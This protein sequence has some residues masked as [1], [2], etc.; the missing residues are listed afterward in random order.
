MAVST[1]SRL[2]QKN[3]AG[4]S[5][6]LFLEVFSGLVLE[7]F[8]FTQLTDDRQ[9]VRVIKNGKSAQFPLIWSTAAKYHTPGVELIGDEISH[10]SK[11]ISIEQLLEADVFIDT[12]DEAM[13]H[14]EVRQ[15]YAHQLGEALANA[16]DTNS[17][18][19]VFVGAAASH[20]ITLAT[21]ENDGLSI[22]TAAL[23]T[24]ASLM[25]AALYDVAQ[26]FD[27]KNVP[28]TDRFCALLPLAWYLLLED[29][30]FIHRDF[31][32]EGSKAHATM[33]FAADIQVLKSNN[34][35][36]ADDT[37]EA[38]VP[39][40]LRDDFRECVGVAWHRQA[41][42]TVKL[43]DLKVESEYDIRRQGTLFVAKYAIGQDFLRT[44]AC[45]SLEDTLIV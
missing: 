36:T 6:A 5:D 43:L 14:Y 3:E 34:I 26:T 22:Q 39:V 9:T 20:P 41:I 11:V 44:E 42:G 2:G 45:I 27:E 32:G 18:R 23:S 13:N 40:V 17:F 19:A 21:P 35:P 10:E 12:L 1:P 4:A 25:K 16:K 28:T 37:G 31:A 38:T 8:D 7:R 33:P 30:E 29:G 15:P 24:T